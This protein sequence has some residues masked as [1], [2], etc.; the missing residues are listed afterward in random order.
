MHKKNTLTK[1]QTKPKLGQSS[2]QI[3]QDEGTFPSQQAKQ[4]QAAYGFLSPTS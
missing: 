2:Q 1:L 3:P 4:E